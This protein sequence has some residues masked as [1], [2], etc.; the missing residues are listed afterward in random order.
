MLKG[1]NVVLTEIRPD[2]SETLYRWI[3]DAEAVRLNAP[4]GPVAYPRHVAWLEALGRDDS[5][6]AFAIRETADGPLVG[7]IQLID[8]HR[9]HRTAELTIRIGS[10][11]KQG[12]GL[13]TEALKLATRFAFDDLN[14]QRLWLRVFQTNTRAIRAY[15]KTGLEVEGVMRRAAFVEGRWLDVIVM[16]V[17]RERP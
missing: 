11:E 3:N 17:L 16:A 6:V 2:D 4:Y 9:I 5:R 12:R 7:T 8:I 1:E 13:G 10:P 15:E 14:L